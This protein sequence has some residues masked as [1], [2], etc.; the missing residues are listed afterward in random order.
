MSIVKFFVV[1]LVV[2]IVDWRLSSAISLDLS[3]SKG[4]VENLEFNISFVKNDTIQNKTFTEYTQFDWGRETNFTIS[5]SMTCSSR[6]PFGVRS[7]TATLVLGVGKDKLTLEW[8][9]QGWSW[10]KARKITLRS[11]T[12]NY[13]LDED[14]FPESV[15]QGKMAQ[16]DLTGSPKSYWNLDEGYVC[17]VGNY[18]VTLG[19]DS[20][21]VLRNISLELFTFKHKS[22]VHCAEQEIPAN[23]SNTFVAKENGTIVAVLQTT[24]EFHIE[25]DQKKGNETV[26]AKLTISPLDDKKVF[27]STSVSGSVDKEKNV[28]TVWIVW[29]TKD[30]EITKKVEVT[31]EI[32]LVLK[33]GKVSLTRTELSIPI[34]TVLGFVHAEK[35]GTSLNETFVPYGGKAYWDKEGFYQCVSLV[36]ETSKDK[37]L[38]LTMKDAKIQAFNGKENF[39][40]EAEV[41]KEDK[42]TTPAPPKTT[43]PAPAPLEFL[44]P[45]GTHGDC[46]L[47]KTDAIELTVGYN[48]KSGEW[49]TTKLT[50]PHDAE[51]DKSKSYCPKKLGFEEEGNDLFGEGVDK[52][53]TDQALAILWKEKVGTKEY[54]REI[55]FYFSDRKTYTTADDGSAFTCYKLS[56][57]GEFPDAEKPKISYENDNITNGFLSG[58]VGHTATC[59]LF[60][61]TLTSTV[62]NKTETELN[63]DLKNVKLMAFAGNA[64]EFSSDEAVCARDKK[65]S[66]SDLIPII[67]GA[68]LAALVVIVLVAYLIGRARARRTGYESV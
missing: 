53:T 63:L 56:F 15:N 60:N 61:F 18:N 27:V 41:C 54:S 24:P 16:L 40:G 26:K 64:T 55:V 66:T 13:L 20:T 43:T 44:Y 2:S 62:E 50:V 7:A 48:N 30:T 45:N 42:T 65:A 14:R 68:C 23:T 33:D 21:L 59:S 1:I 57:E 11:V 17:P 22:V 34:S 37:A 47:L 39:T 29:A 36:G 52:N 25:Y 3:C 49:V 58:M 32:E 10:G 46:F 12:Y 38:T 67:V 35:E 9:L 31:W 8:Y 4:F 5:P 28:T 19:Q 6:W 51:V